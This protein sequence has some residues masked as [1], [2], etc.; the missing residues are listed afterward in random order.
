[1]D[2]GA[3]GMAG[4]NSR[5]VLWQYEALPSRRSSHCPASELLDKLQPLSTVTLEEGDRDEVG[6]TERRGAERKRRTSNRVAGH[7]Q[8]IDG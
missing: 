3:S 7:R 2:G 4:G 5:K 8:C 1:M 6:M